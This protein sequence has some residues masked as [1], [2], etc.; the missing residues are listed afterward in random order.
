MRKKGIFLS[1]RRS[2]VELDDCW[3]P[4]NY[5]CSSRKDILADYHF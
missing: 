1:P 4:C 3:P 5:S 2:A